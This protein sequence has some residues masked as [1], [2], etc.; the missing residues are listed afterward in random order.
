MSKN[1]KG[2]PKSEEFRKHLSLIQKGN[3]SRFWKGGITE[4]N[5]NIRGSVEMK[6]WREA[7]FKRDNYTCQHCGLRSGQGVKVYLQADH[8]KPFA[9]FP[10]L[11]FELTNGRSLCIDCHKKTDTY[12][13]RALNYFASP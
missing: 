12:M 5:S 1:R 11:R 8:I 9:Y 6:L 3:K 10:E 2:K 13:G 7:V 4:V